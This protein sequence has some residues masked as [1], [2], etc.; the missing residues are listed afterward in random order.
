MSPIITATLLCVLLVAS[1]GIAQTA[2]HFP[3]PPAQAQISDDQGFAVIFQAMALRENILHAANLSPQD[4]TT[5]IRIIG[6]FESRFRELSAALDRG[7]LTPRE[8]GEQ[9]DQLARSTR[10]NLRASMTRPGFL[11]LERFIRMQ[12]ARIRVN[13]VQPT[14]V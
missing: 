6:E 11:R 2:P 5:A 7:I 13:T 3:A 12:I 4:E 10:R 14:E 9:R 1:P 8:F